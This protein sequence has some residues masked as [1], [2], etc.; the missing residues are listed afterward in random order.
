[1]EDL[2]AI[3]GFYTGTYVCSQGPTPLTLTIAPNTTSKGLDAIF[4]FGG[5]TSEVPAGSFL[6]EGTLR[7]GV[8]KLNATDW[9]VQPDGYVSV[10]LRADVP[11]ASADRISGKL[12]D[13][14]CDTFTVNR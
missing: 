9:I 2:T 5:G 10:D 14:A 4:S 6:M 8:L 13:P 3:T 7:N 11:D 1:M 12:L